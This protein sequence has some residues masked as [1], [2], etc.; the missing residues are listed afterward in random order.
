M[1]ALIGVVVWLL[2]QIPMPEPFKK[3]IL[4]VAIILLILWLLTGNSGLSLRLP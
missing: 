4:A 1:I 2:F 3:I